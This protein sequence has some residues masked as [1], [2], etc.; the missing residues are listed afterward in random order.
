MAIRTYLQ[1][2]GAQH[3]L[4][5]DNNVNGTSDDLG[6]SSIPTAVSLNSYSSFDTKPVCEGVTHS[7]KSVTDTGNVT[8][9]T[10]GTRDDINDRSDIYQ[11]YTIIL[12]VNQAD[13]FNTT[14]IYKQGGGTNNFA[15]MGGALT[16]WQAADSG[17]PFL[18]VQS[19]SLTQAD[20]PYLLSGVWERHTEHA[21][22]GNRVL[23]YINGVLQGVSELTG[24]DKFPSH[25]SIHIGNSGNALQ[26]FA[27][28]TFRTQTVEKNM[29]FWATFN[30]QNLTAQDY[31][32]I[33]E[34]MT[35]SEALIP[36][37]T[38]ANQQAALDALSGTTFENVNCAIRIL[39][40]TDVTNYRLFVDNITF[41]ADD[42]IKDISVQFV[43]SGTLTLENT[44][45]TEIKYVSTPAEVETNS[46]ILTGGGSINVVL[47]TTR[48]TTPSTITNSLATKLVFE[49]SGSYE[50]SGGSISEVENVSGGEVTV[51][52][53]NGAPTPTIIGDSITL[54]FPDQPINI[55]NIS[56]GSRLRIYN[57]TKATETVNTVVTGTSYT[58]SYQEGVQY[59]DGDVVRVYLTK[60]GKKEWVGDVIDTSNGFNVLASQIEDDI[61]LA[62]GVDGSTVTKF[63]AD[64]PNNQVDIQV[65]QDFSM[66]EFYTWWI[67]NLT[68]E[69][70]IREFFG[71]ITAIDQANFRINNSVVNLFFDNLTSTNLVQT[72]NRRI[73]R[74][75]GIYP[76]IPATAG[77]GGIDIV[78][79]N[80]ILIAETGLNAQDSADISNIVQNAA[81]A[82]TG[83]LG[84]ADD[85]ADTVE[86]AA[87]TIINN[88]TP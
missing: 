23:F 28:A 39:Q 4:D 72:D 59:S 6:S 14:C 55:T 63:V 77:G 20:R 15:F 29:N 12:W 82:L 41:N 56:S 35:F 66:A 86:E 65:A 51:L 84:N 57:V 19:K 3:L 64:Y 54:T 53:S 78:W 68:T 11:K 7:L 33:F 79:R 13:I 36:A 52:I 44:N 31:R 38:V 46:G 81:T 45:G 48:V 60:L 88:C 25:G 67:Y 49:T 80:T 30:D 50:I 21:G 43:G 74:T 8:G 1:S 75:D 2:L 26:S 61:Y 37:D 58:D 40:A 85:I 16:T 18:I 22:S 34:R 73:Y 5:L 69:A 71:G 24:T 62:M 76:V 17:E 32:D 83:I 87:D 9:A 70:G 42:N 10:I 47:N 27:E